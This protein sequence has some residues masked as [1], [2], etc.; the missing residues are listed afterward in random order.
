M[1]ARRFAPPLALALCAGLLA[2]AV[3]VAPHVSGAALSGEAA[4]VALV[5]LH[6]PRAAFGALAGF[7]LALSGV[8][9]Q[10]TLK[11]PLASPYTLGI[12]SGG[13]VGAVAVVQSG[14][15]W[16]GALG[17]SAVSLGALA[18]AGA[19]AGL[20]YA[21]A[22]WRGHAAE[23]LLLTGVAMAL[24]GGAIVTLLHYLSLEGSALDLAAIV[25]WSMG[26]LE[27]VG[28]SRVGAAAVLVGLGSAVVLSVAP[29]LDVAAL[30]DESALGLGVDPA[31][32]RRRVFLGSSVV[33][34]GVVAFAGPVGFVGLIVPHAV[35][36]LVG[37]DPR[38]LLPCAAC[39]GG[40]FLVACDLVARTALYPTTLPINVIT[41]AV[42][43]PTFV[44]I[45][46]RRSTSA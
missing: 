17:L 41:Y 20:V 34:A 26:G 14:L 29:H 13:A 25:R 5:E 31:R 42:G 2:L 33:T 15:A 27:V 22:S 12:A 1:S 3:G 10:A 7:G 43:C 28:W 30:D 21:L 40:A 32:V 6:R 46:L 45:L 4:R 8:A 38:V 23:T 18:G 19:T 24:L 37:P 36:R 39:A 9:L 35:R 16:S 11:N 44:W